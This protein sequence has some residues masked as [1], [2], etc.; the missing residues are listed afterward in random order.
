MPIYR[1]TDVLDTWFS[2]GLWPFATMGWPDDTEDMA[3]F[4]PTSV[5]VTA[6]DII[7]FWVARMMMQGL[8]L[9]G[10]VPFKD[11]YIHAIVRDE[12]GA[13]MS[14]S[15]GN[16]IDPLVLVD[17][18]G[19][20][21]LRFTLSAMAAMGRDIRLSEQR[22]EGYRNFGT[23][24]WNAARFLEM[25]ECAPVDGFDP[26]S[27]QETVNKWIVGEA[28]KAARAVTSA[29]EAY[30]FN[31]AADAAYKFSR[32]QFCDWYLELIKPIMS[33]DNEVAKT[34]TRACASWAFDQILKTLHPFMPFITEELWQ[35]T[36]D[37]RNDFLMSSAWPELGDA[38]I[39]A[40]AE[41]DIA[42]L[43]DLVTEVRSVRTE[44]NIPPSRKGKMVLI[45]ASGKTIARMETYKDALERMARMSSWETADAA[46]KASIQAVV[47]EATIALPLEGLID[48]DAERSRIDKEIAK[49]QEE[50]DKIDKKLSNK[51]FVD[52]APEKVVAEQHARRRLS[53]QS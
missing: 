3:R 24:L 16:V 52:R 6:F 47:G 9:T 23:K 38:Y 15:K 14:K 19:A 10:Q 43:I 2:S 12:K 35:Q 5:V 29:I 40:G 49:A 34:E 42:W 20:D 36:V 1:D 11:V 46:P 45:G 30:R 51:N 41:T 48:M 21:A 18:Y 39:D 13:K 25:N 8:H 53:Q 37:K 32:G 27:C 44:M 50:I 31:D 26:L 7:F 17:K 33:G 22:I 4:Y 28:A